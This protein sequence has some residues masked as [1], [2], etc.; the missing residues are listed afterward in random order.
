MS[1]HLIFSDLPAEYLA[2][3]FVCCLLQPN[4][5]FKLAETGLFFATEIATFYNNAP[6][7]PHAPIK[8]AVP[9]TPVVFTLCSTLV[10]YLCQ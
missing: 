3:L 1:L 5:N 6:G 2:S 4:D 7:H 10:K 9:P 8:S